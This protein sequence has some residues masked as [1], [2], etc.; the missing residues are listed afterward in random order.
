MAL[1]LTV[2][3]FFSDILSPYPAN[4]KQKKKWWAKG[5]QEA[6]REIKG[7]PEEHPYLGL[8]FL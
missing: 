3:S 7:H 1:V 5:P 4:W 2:Y 8:L 6:D